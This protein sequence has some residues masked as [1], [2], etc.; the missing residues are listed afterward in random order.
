MSDGLLDG[1]FGVGPNWLA[2]L[3][4]VEAALA[5][6]A[7]TV[8]RIPSATTKLIVEHVAQTHRDT[9]QLG[10]TLLAAA[11]P[12]TFGR[13]A[14][15]W[16]AGLADAC[17]VLRRVRR[18]V[19]AVQLGGPVGVLDDPALFAIGHGRLLLDDLRVDATRMRDGVR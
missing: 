16:H 9:P 2:A 3:L 14:A 13:L 6:A 8:G 10:R 4:D 1:M 7:S 11:L 5:G 12:T 17:A 18:E 15:I 19:L